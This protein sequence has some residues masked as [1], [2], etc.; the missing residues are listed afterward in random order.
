MLMIAAACLSCAQKM[1]TQPGHR[2]FDGTALEVAGNTAREPLP[3]TVESR[4]G[5]DGKTVV[6]DPP[7]DVNSDTTPFPLTWDVLERGKERFEINCAVCHGLT[8]YGDGT[9]VRRGFLGPPS[10]H[11]QR[12]RDAPM[13][14]FY[15]VITHGFGGMAR[16]SD[17]VDFR[18]RWAVA[19]YIRT[20]QVSQNARIQD[21]PPEEA[22]R[23]E[24]AK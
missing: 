4:F 17:Q 21:V 24:G 9:V 2:P 15:D 11:D 20:L 22:V 13:G 16:Y 18:D 10:L 8:G 19:A 6:Q 14:H 5:V 3:G 7:V 12:L 23:L 1:G